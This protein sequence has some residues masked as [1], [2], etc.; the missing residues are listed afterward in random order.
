MIRIFVKMFLNLDIPGRVVILSVLIDIDPLLAEE[1]E[2]MR[3]LVTFIH[4]VKT[5]YRPVSYHNW[6]HAFNVAQAMFFFVTQ[7]EIVS[8][9]SAEEKLALVIGAICHD[10]DHRGCNN[11]YQQNNDSELWKYYGTST[12][13]R[14]HVCRTK[15]ILTFPDNH[16]FVP[17]DKLA[18][19]VDLIEHA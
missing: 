14:H 5:S 8:V 17:S 1:A 15:Q 16:R 9:L 19:V 11:K 10:L 7:T 18:Q 2:P 3:S 6:R 4:A 12:L 13:E